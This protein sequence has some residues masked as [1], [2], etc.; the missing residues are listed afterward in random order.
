MKITGGCAATKSDFIG[1]DT[2]TGKVISFI[3]A[4]GHHDGRTAEAEC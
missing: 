3:P 1:I 4:L 2:N